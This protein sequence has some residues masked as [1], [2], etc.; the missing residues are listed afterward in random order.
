MSSS[1]PPSYITTPLIVLVAVVLASS[2]T[3]VAL[4]GPDALVGEPASSRA[5]ADGSERSDRAGA[6]DGPPPRPP[7]ELLAMRTQSWGVT[8]PRVPGELDRLDRVVRLT[9]RAPD[10]VMWYA[11]W[12]AFED[13]PTQLARRVARRG[14]LPEISWE[15][16]DPAGGRQQPRYD[17]AGIAAGDNDRYL[18]RW[19]RQAEAYGKPV[20]IRFMHAMNGDWYPWGAG[21]RGVRAADHVAAWRHVV[22][23]FRDVGAHNVIWSWS[24]N[25]PFPGS[26]PLDS[27]FPGDRWVDRVALDGYNW[28]GF[29]PGTSWTSFA[30]VMGEGLDQLADLSDRPAYIGEVG[31]PER[32][33]DKARWVRCMFATAAEDPRIR[34]LTWFDFR[35]EADWRI[36][37]SPASAAAFRQGLRDYGAAGSGA[38]AA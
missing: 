12:A 27:L 21:R 31:C 15:P 33:G 13:F 8:I 38:P 7:A 24:P 25:V 16:W 29:R 2:V 9:G 17:L 20:V 30:D 18:R 36:D 11:S 26:V 23:T 10:R 28:A 19:A 22:E 6:T 3:A 1:R 35:K 37:S 14:A 4:R 5:A 34:G 32:G